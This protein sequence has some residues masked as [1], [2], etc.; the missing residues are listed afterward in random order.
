MALNNNFNPMIE[1]DD[2]D[3]MKEIY[4]EDYSKHITVKED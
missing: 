3:L 1:Q 2:V 4:N